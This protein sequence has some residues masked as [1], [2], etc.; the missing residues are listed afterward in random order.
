MI[1]STIHRVEPRASR[2]GGGGGGKIPL[3][4]SGEFAQLQQELR[5]QK[6]QVAQAAQTAS[7]IQ[8]EL[9]TQVVRLHDRVCYPREAGLRRFV[10]F[11]EPSRLG[12]SCCVYG[13]NRPT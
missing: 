6:A 9:G 8:V 7:N 5:Y 1:C 11:C 4:R 12:G 10:V 2:S 3:F 13:F